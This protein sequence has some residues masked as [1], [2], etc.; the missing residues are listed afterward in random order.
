VADV[1]TVEGGS[2][3]RA[4]ATYDLIVVNILASVIVQLLEEGMADALRSGGCVIASGIIDEQEADVV[5][6][7]E[8]HGIEV[9]GRRCERD[10]V[11][12]I[13]RR[14]V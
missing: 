12:L 3:N 10:W 7:F 11:A 9:T 14:R 5:G 6:A 13:G 2:L 8:A 4:Q 1:V